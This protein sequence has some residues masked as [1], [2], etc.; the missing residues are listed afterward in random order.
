MRSKKLED[1]KIKAF[2]V[3]NPGNPTSMA[4]DAPTLKKIVDLV[5]KKRPDLL[6][7]TDDV[8]GT[9]VPGFRSLMAELPENTI[10]VYSFFRNTSGARA[11]GW[12]SSPLTRRRS[13]TASGRQAARQGPGGARQALHLDHA[14]AAQ[15]QDDRPDRRRQPRRR[16]AQPHGW[17]VATAAGDDEHVLDERVDGHGKALPEGLHGYLPELAWRACWKGCRWTSSPTRTSP[18]SRRHDR[19]RVLAAQVCRRGH[20]TPVAERRTS[21]RSISSSGSPRTMRSCSSTAVVFDGARTGAF[22]SPSPT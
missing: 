22:A 5:K 17:P 4:I 13:S 3:V 9:F 20:E 21:I 1:P 19:F 16:G 2:F 6:L 10:G 15:A 8:Y 14:G 12:A 7:L 11:G 18:Y